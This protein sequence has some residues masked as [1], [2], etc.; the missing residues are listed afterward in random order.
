MR[1]IR[2]PAELQA[3]QARIA[4]V[5]AQAHQADPSRA[6]SAGRSLSPEEVAELYPV[7]VRPI[8]A[9][10]RPRPG[11]TPLWPAEQAAVEAYRSRRRP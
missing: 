10:A 2:P 7:R 9:T 4:Q 5:V 3:E 11:G 8:P 1:P 6:P